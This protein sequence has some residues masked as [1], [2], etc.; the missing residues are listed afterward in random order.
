MTMNLR[1]LLKIFLPFVILASAVAGYYYLKNS[2]P[3]RKKPALQEKVWQ[4]D[5]VVANAASLSPEL[6]LYGEVESPELLKSA[7][8][9]NAVV[10]AVNV[11]SGDR[12]SKGQILLNL[13]KRDFNTE[14]IEA[15]GS[16]QDLQHQI[17]EQNIRYQNNRQIL[18]TEKDLLV[19]AE[20]EV[21]RMERLKTQN[22]GSESTLNS[23]K[24]ELGIRQLS[25][26]SRQLDID[27]HP[28]QL[29]KMETLKKQFQSRQ[30]DA[31][32][33]IARST[34]TAPFDGIVSQVDVTAGDRVMTG[35]TMISL[36]P[37]NTL[38]VRAH[39]PLRYI[40][41]IQQ[42]LHAGNTLLAETINPAG[43]K[44]LKLNRF[45]GQARSTGLDGYFQPQQTDVD[46]NFRIGELMSINL[47]LPAVENAYAIPFQAVYG[48][49]RIY[50]LKQGRL[51][52][53]DVK[54]V[55][56]MTTENEEQRLIIQSS[57][58]ISGD[59]IVTTHLPNAVTGLKVEAIEQ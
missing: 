31:E 3:E 21:N 34:I 54:T 20:A 10:A 59:N 40:D 17:E 51:E 25:V 2:K 9:G 13:D 48:N 55:G 27:N 14:L 44:T 7:S 5:T 42:Y 15:Q 28:L 11:R 39:I 30:K 16:L 8:P 26:L 37:Q 4:V 56:N 29:K 36:F 1:Q 35:Q 24:T 32:L 38:E 22:L 23:S 33:K 50:R 19:Y 58:L 41:S 45:A 12:V 18:A 57:E 46:N 52:G 6:V 47:S 49:S 53:I 43:T